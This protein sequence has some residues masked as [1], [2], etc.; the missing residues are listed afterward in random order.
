M[1]SDHRQRLG[2]LGET[3]AC[4]HLEARGYS[5]IARNFRTRHGE[6]DLVVA[7]SHC[8]VICEVKTRVGR[9]AGIEPLAAVGRAKRSQVRRMARQWLAERSP[10][11][12]RPAEL[13]F[14][15]IGIT[16]DGRGRL[17]EL[18]HVEAAF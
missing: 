15:A 16:L 11:G 2:V 18:D 3:L 14:D 1:T 9:R 8:L 13:R 17:V 4:R 6:L 7:D 12:P 10:E 5:V